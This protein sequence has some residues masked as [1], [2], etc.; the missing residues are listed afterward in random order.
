MEINHGFNFTGSTFDVSKYKGTI[1]IVRN[2]EKVSYPSSSS[3][4]QNLVSEGV[5][6]KGSN[7][8]KGWS[9]TPELNNTY[10]VIYT[11]QPFYIYRDNVESRIEFNRVTSS[12]HLLSSLK[13]D[14]DP[15]LITRIDV[16]PMED[17]WD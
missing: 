14:L 11:S 13:Y 15:N 7:F 5:I 4:V 8:L 12:G 1:K 10:I 16:Y 17:T 9:N 6:S 3:V 2:K